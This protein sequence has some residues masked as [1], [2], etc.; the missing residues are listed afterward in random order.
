MDR[1][2]RQFYFNGAY[3]SEAVGGLLGVSGKAVRARAARLR[4]GHPEIRV[5]KPGPVREPKPKAE[6]KPL[7]T[8][9]APVNF[10][11]PEKPS[12]PLADRIAAALRLGALSAPSL[13][14]MLGEKEIHVSMQLS[15]MAHAGCAQAGPAAGVG[16][17]HR[18]WS[19]A[20]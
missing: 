3:T 4:R 13:A 18:I 15:A 8:H 5:R 16:A 19:L 7:N 10:K 9:R 14:S 12:A 17:R 6:A 2:L 20:A 11:A 1:Q